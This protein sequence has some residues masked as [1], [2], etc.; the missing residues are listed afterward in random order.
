VNF[1]MSILSSN[2]NVLNSGEFY[3]LEVDT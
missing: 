2:V 1:E 3:T